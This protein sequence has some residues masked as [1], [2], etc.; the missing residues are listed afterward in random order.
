LLQK[1]ELREQGKEIKEEKR[2]G[3]KEAKGENI[4]NYTKTHIV[5]LS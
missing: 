2:R 3:K 5:Y 1:R 4:Y